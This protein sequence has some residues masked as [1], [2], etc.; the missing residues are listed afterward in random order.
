MENAIRDENH[1][2]VL[3]GVSSVDWTPLP[4]T[5]NP[6]TGAILAEA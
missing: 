1:V 4:I 2:T 5:V 6:A 3:M